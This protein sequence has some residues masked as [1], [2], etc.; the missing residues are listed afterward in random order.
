[1]S[2]HLEPQTGCALKVAAG[3]T[4]R[5]TS[6][7][8]GQVA[9]LTAFAA[10]DLGE[11]LSSGRTIDY[12]GTILVTTGSV[13]Y[14]NRST[15]ML[16]ITADTAGRHDFLI[17]P[18]SAEMFERLY[19]SAG[20]PS[21]FTNLATHLARFGIHGDRIPTTLNLFMV[22]TVDPGDGHITIEA[23]SCAAGDHVDLRAEIDLVVG[24]TACSAELTNQ[25]VFGPIAV[26]VVAELAG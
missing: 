14:S 22:V 25:G 16:T 17:S 23:P 21:C 18:C 8:G 3:E 19:G 20:H 13:L 4:L 12:G 2:I 9:D 5:V 15:P 11:W 26:E 1:M 7:T 10:A 24:V 6:P